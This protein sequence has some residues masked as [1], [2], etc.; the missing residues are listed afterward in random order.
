MKQAVI[1]HQKEANIKLLNNHFKNLEEVELVA[2]VPVANLKE[3]EIN[4]TEIDLIFSTVHR[5]VVE[6]SLNLSQLDLTFVEPEIVEI[7]LNSIIKGDQLLKEYKYKLKKQ[8]IIINS[9]H[10]AMIAINHKGKITLINQAAKELLNFDKD[11]IG[12]DIKRLVPN[13]GLTKVLETGKKEINQLQSLGDKVIITNRVP[14]KNKDGRVMAVVAVF[15]DVTEVKTLAEKLTNSKEI[16]GMLEAIINSTQ[17]AISV[18][19]E[20]GRG[21]MINPAYT[22]I[23]GLTEKDVIGKSATVDIAEGDSMHLK[24]LKTKKPVS[25]IPMKVGP[26]H[27]EVIV[28]VSPILV[29]GELKGSVG[30]I[31]DI[32]NIRQLNRELSEAK[33][34]IRDLKAKYTFADII[35]DTPEITLAI[36]KAKKASRT[37]ATVLLRGDSGTGKELFA[38]AI[39]NASKRSNKPFVSVNCPAISDSLLES[40]LFGYEEGA[41]TGAKKGGKKGLFEEANRGTIFLDEIGKLDFNLQA[42]LLRVL[43]EKEIT[44]VGGTEP[45]EVDVRVIVATNANLREE[46][47][48]GSFRED[49]YYRINVVPISIPPLCHRKGDIPKLVRML[50]RKYTQDYG[51]LVTDISSNALD[52]LMEYDWPGNVRELENIIG[53][54][55]IN[56]GQTDEVIT[57]K[58][59]P[60]LNNN[61]QESNTE[62]NDFIS[63]IEVRSKTLSEVVAKAEVK[64][65]KAALKKTDGNK[66][67]AAE[68]LDISIR[69]LY[70]KLN[71]L[72][73]D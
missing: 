12:Y 41:F 55:I 33:R 67:K 29:E 36:K 27:K 65:I 38:H 66:T 54:T 63:E 39:H 73:I 11:Y 40:E 6:D 69:S 58:H 14:I 9:T 20:T 7:L 22:Q 30:V 25:G 72:K 5:E 35:G 18:V 59:L 64:A 21:I 32:S 53:R 13:T 2:L 1:L 19:D 31:H 48:E 61:N 51:K 24:V 68:L 46:V 49:L 34:M 15:R 16:R 26:Q 44:R 3:V 10:D 70:Y 42:K 71:K 56:M 8:K 23:T 62:D 4:F 45:K 52:K 43:Q 47:E 37:P 50:L 28:N 57:G 60:V 17:D